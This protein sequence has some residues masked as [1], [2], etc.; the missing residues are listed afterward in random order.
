MTSKQ[1][2]NA[3]RKKGLF[4]K[5]PNGEIFEPDEASVIA[6]KLDY[7]IKHCTLVDPLY[8]CKVLQQDLKQLNKTL[9]E[10]KNEIE[11][12]YKLLNNV[13]DQFLSCYDTTKE[14]IQSNHKST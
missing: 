3:A 5:F 4:I 6:K 13:L 1:K 14:E 2:M 10:T 11:Q 12:K 8:E 7:S 9:N